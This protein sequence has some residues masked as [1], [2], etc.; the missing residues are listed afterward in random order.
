MIKIPKIFQIDGKPEFG[1]VKQIEV[2][3]RHKE[4]IE[5]GYIEM[6]YIYMPS[7][8]TLT[9]EELSVSGFCTRGIGYIAPDG[10]CYETG[11]HEFSKDYPKL[12][13][14]LT[15]V[16]TRSGTDKDGNIV[17]KRKDI[18]YRELA[19]PDDVICPHCNKRINKD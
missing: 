10:V 13:S 17:I 15:I 4:V 12:Q 14:R 18:L 5:R 1:N 2:L 7:K 6:R 19:F 16:F 9:K 8:F 11:D 3:Q